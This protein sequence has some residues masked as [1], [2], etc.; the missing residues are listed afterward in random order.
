M[1]IRTNSSFIIS[2]CS[3]GKLYMA[4]NSSHESNS[5]STNSIILIK[6]ASSEIN[7]ENREEYFISSLS[8]CSGKHLIILR[9]SE[10]NMSYTYVKVFSGLEA[11]SQWEASSHGLCTLLHRSPIWSEFEFATT[12]QL[13]F[14]LFSLVCWSLMGCCSDCWVW[15]EREI[16]AAY[17]FPNL[18]VWENV[19]ADGS[20][21]RWKLGIKKVYILWEHNSNALKCCGIFCT[22]L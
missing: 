2:R 6:E 7:Y 5:Y 10:C 15:E 1:A 13:F 11:Y 4:G 9:L 19:F 8:C 16:I 14:I 18:W 20:L 12:I 17:I 21:G 22:T 3:L